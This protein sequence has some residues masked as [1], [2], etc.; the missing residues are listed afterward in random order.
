M[1]DTAAT[2]TPL[3][4]M[5]DQRV[6]KMVRSHLRLDAMDK[7]APNGESFDEL[8][9]FST[10]RLASDGGIIYVAGWGLDRYRQNPVFIASHD[11]GGEWSAQSMDELVMGS[12]VWVDKRNDVPMDI[13]PN[14]KGLVG[15]V[16]F[17]STPFG[18]NIRTL[19]AE[20]GLNM[21]SVRWDWRTEE[22][23]HPFEEEVAEHGDGLFWVV[24]RCD[25]IETSGVI[26]GADPGALIIRSR[27]ECGVPI[28]DRESI[29][30]CSI[31]PEALEAYSRCRSMGL[32]LGA[33]EQLMRQVD[34]SLA[35]EISKTDDD[36]THGRVAVDGGAVGD[37]LTGFD[38][39]LDMFDAVQG[40]MAQ[41]RD[42]LAASRAELEALTIESSAEIEEDDDDDER[43]TEIEVRL[44][45][46]ER[47]GARLLD[48]GATL[49]KALAD[50]REAFELV[51]AAREAEP[52]NDDEDEEAEEADVEASAA[53]SGT[54]VVS[55]SDDEGDDEEEDEE[56]EP[57]EP[58]GEDD[59][60]TD[61]SADAE[62]DLESVFA[63]DAAA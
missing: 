29:G 20:G 50:S 28:L 4:A 56:E 32:E 37:A 7:T 42:A 44:T 14:G 11:L 39:A 34:T 46:L 6:R 53:E 21:T 16:R 33:F 59:H 15:A 22:S 31:L 12:T 48:M 54:E 1:P 63:E 49:E 61:V 10:E 57:E 8:F 26:L 40:Q 19:Y 13:A 18:Q 52:E 3:L 17:A 9:V 51:M 58:A 36:D 41:V 38:E 62:V 5:P 2:K 25:L 43:A 24:T 27:N 55:E 23:R 45:V 35:P 30:R 60:A 47:T